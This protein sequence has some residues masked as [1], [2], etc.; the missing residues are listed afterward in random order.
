MKLKDLFFKDK[1]KILRYGW[2]EKE[3]EE[4]A[5]ER[6][7]FSEKNINPEIN[8]NYAKIIIFIA[9]PIFMAA[10]SFEVLPAALAGFALSAAAFFIVRAKTRNFTAYNGK[11]GIKLA[12][13]PFAVIT[14]AVVFGAV[15]KPFKIRW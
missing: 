3:K 13:L 12:L 14:I 9:A 5:K 6:G 8:W 2:T 11:T 7:L 4:A 10:A 1:A 15:F